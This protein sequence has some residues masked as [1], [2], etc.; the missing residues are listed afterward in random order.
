[1]TVTMSTIGPDPVSHNATDCSE[2]ILDF[3]WWVYHKLSVMCKCQSMS[4]G[5]TSSIPTL[6]LFVDPTPLSL[7]QLF[8]H[9]STFLSEKIEKGPKTAQCHKAQINSN[10]FL[11][12]GIIEISLLIR[13]QSNRASLGFGRTGDFHHD[14]KA[15]KS[16]ATA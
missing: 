3:F 9:I 7:P 4:V 15:D 5:N 14:W 8:Y 16:A 11:E 13:P 1:M 10:W 6:L 12:H 2:D